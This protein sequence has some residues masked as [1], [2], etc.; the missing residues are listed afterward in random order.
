MGETVVITGAGLVTSLG[1]SLDETWAALVEG[2]SGI[3]PIEGFPAD[4]FRTKTAAQVRGL[5]AKALDIPPR[6]ERVVDTHTFMLIKCLRDAFNNSGLEGSSIDRDEVAFFAGMGGVDYRIEDLAPAIK[7]SMD[8]DGG[9]NYDKFYSD[10]FRE[11]HPMWPLAMLNN[12]AFCQAAIALVLR[13]DNTV[14]SPHAEAGAQAIYES[15]AS[16]A[17]GISPAALAAGVSEKFSPINLARETLA[18]TTSASACRP[19]SAERDGTVLGEGCAVLALEGEAEASKRGAV[20]LA[21]ITG[22][23]EA[24][25]W[26]GQSAPGA[27]AITRAMRAALEDSGLKPS[28]VDV[29]IAHGDG[30][31]KG[32]ASEIEAINE[33]FA[34][35]D[36]KVYS[37]KGALG[38]MLA[39]SPAVDVALAARMISDGKVPP[40]LGAEPLDGKVKFG[41]VTGSALE[42]DIRRVMVGCTSREGHCAALVVEAAR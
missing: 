40:T 1:L 37:S 39:G 27:D 3:C 19:F 21:K 38:H 25:A 33:A 26:K 36:V 14:L 5:N 29:L 32:D 13:G 24:F 41:V 7:A 42:R 10:A 8:K 11:I 22:Y 20:P 4:G 35:T 16:V 9:I 17:E 2:R 15:W 12:I 23:G 31:Q 30:T 6:E 34:N 28:D 18:G